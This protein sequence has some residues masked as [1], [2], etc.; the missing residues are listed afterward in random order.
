MMKIPQK[1]YLLNIKAVP[2]SNGV[3]RMSLQAFETPSSQAPASHPLHGRRH[4]E[5]NLVLTELNPHIVIDHRDDGRPVNLTTFGVVRETCPK[6]MQS[7][8]HLILRQNNVRTAHLFC[9]ECHSCF[10]AHYP[11]GASALAI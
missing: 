10:D 4:T 9:A 8:L 11:S 5:D 6:C 2:V 7:H 3:Y 1:V